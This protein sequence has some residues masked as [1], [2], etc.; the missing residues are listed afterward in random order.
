MLC[1]LAKNTFKSEFNP[2]PPVNPQLCDS[3]D[4]K[5]CSCNCPSKD[6]T[7]ANQMNRANRKFYA[8]TPEYRPHHASDLSKFLLSLWKEKKLCDIMFK[9]DTRDY[10][11]HRLALAMFSTKYR[12]VFQKQQNNNGPMYT[13]KLKRTSDFA[14]NVESFIM[15]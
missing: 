10:C 11:A 12:D 3:C 4:L 1:G 9:I 2:S 5:S 13:I 7:L 15:S 6:A 14:L 8:N